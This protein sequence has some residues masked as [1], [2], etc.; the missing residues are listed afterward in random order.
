MPAVSSEGNGPSVSVLFGAL[1]PSIP[2]PPH[3]K[4]FFLSGGYTAS[5]T[6]EI[7][8]HALRWKQILK[9]FINEKLLHSFLAIFSEAIKP[10]QVK[11]TCTP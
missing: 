9:N 4:I 2:L 10:S 11:F 7:Y 8:H 5:K 3:Q 1:Y 6:S